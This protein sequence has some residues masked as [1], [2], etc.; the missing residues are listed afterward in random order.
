MAAGDKILW[1]T[2][3]GRVIGTSSETTDS[4]TFTALTL[5]GTI[6]VSLI[7]GKVY[8]VECTA[9]VASTVAT[10]A[11]Q[12]SLVEDS[13]AGAEIARGRVIVDASAA[14]APGPVP[15]R[16]LYTAVATGSKTFVVAAQRA[17][18]SGNVRR[19]AGT[20]FPQVLTVTC[21]GL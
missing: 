13:T 11:V 5:I 9:Q 19:E 7:S 21:T 18:G 10:D 20:T 2:A 6:T 16:A 1:V 4:S 15:L 3:P 14:N 12:V 17:A 8:K